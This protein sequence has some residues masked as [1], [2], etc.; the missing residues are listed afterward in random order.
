MGW[1]G[2]QASAGSG[3][4]FFIAMAAATAAAAMSKG[5][6]RFT[7]MSLFDRGNMSLM[8]DRLD[9][10]VICVPDLAEAS[11]KFEIEYGLVSVEGGRHQGQGTANRLIP[12]GDW[13][14]ELLAVVDPDEAKTSALGTWTAHRS[15]RPG[16]DAV[17]LRPDNFDD[18]IVE[19]G[20]APTEMSR[21]T[22][23][24]HLLKW[25]LAGFKFTV[26]TGL[27]FF[28]DWGS[29]CRHAPGCDPHVKWAAPAE[30]KSRHLFRG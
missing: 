22:P 18:R 29:T 10:V 14:I 17:C 12:L 2:V 30:R 27:P 26:S 1:T 3:S 11:R 13:Y 5:T 23:E 7:I 20:I 21:V 24:G 16:A 28:I 6:R 9:H 15:A 25:R 8:T 4:D 19:L